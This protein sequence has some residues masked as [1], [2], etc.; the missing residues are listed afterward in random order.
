MVEYCLSIIKVMAEKYDESE[1]EGLSLEEKNDFRKKLF[2][3]INHINHVNTNAEKLAERL[4]E[5]AEVEDD[6]TFAKRL[7][8][9]TRSHDQSKFVGIEFEALNKD[10][11]EGLFKIAIN[12]HQQTNDHH[13]EYYGDIR[14]MPDIAIAEFCCDITARSQEMGTDVRVWLKD[15]GMKRWGFSAQTKVYQ[16]IKRFLDLLLDDQFK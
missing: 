3:I 9:R 13:P 2:G 8:E 14:K 7:I 4:I 1:G 11:S 5:V 6:L 12:Q 10:K 16:K 15:V